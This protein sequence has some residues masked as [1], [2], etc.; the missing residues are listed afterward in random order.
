MKAELKHK[1]IYVFSVI[2]FA[3]A[4]EIAARMANMP[5]VLPSL[6]SVLRKLFELSGTKQFWKSLAFSFMRVISAFGI[7]TILG[8]FLGFASGLC[9]SIQSFLKFPFSI[10]KATPVVALI[11]IALFW[12]SSQK[13]PVIC[14]VL[15]TLPVIYDA[16][17]GALQNA[18]KNLLD[19]SRIFHLSFSTRLKHV[20]FPL[21]KPY[22]LTACKTV[23]AQS[24]KVVAA[25]EILSVPRWALG[26]MLQEK[27]ILLE[28]ASV[29]ALVLA[30]TVFCILSEKILFSFVD[31][32]GA[33]LFRLYRKRVGFFAATAS[34][35]EPT[36]W[37]K[38]TA[39][40]PG[41]FLSVENLSFSYK[42]ENNVSCGKEIFNNF[43]LTFKENKTYAITG[44]SGSGKTTLLK[45]LSGTIKETEYSGK[46]TRPETSFIFQEPCLVPNTSVFENAVLP[47]L[48]KMP[49]KEAYKE[50]IY[51]LEKVGLK[52][53]VFNK[54][55]SLSG[56][57]KQ[58]LQA[59]RAFAFKAPVL[60]MDEGTASL[61]ENSRKDLW[62][63]I[64]N[65][66]SENPRTFIFV[67][68]N[69]EEAS[70]QAEES[71]SL[72]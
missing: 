33:T 59:A 45:I 1:G 47:L 7:T 51:Y 57:E 2:F 20:Y 48:D 24:W 28:P 25:G 38:S 4:W 67:T 14:A 34:A 62:N 44:P 69:P 16:V 6:L 3:L 43:S 8:L 61:D 72:L 10:I 21:T 17:C 26:T 15:M 30:L 63:T 71:I 18:N 22:I 54:A 41:A 42:T 49:V 65:L 5:L 36:V 31:F 52:E 23:F 12:F 13:L 66:L 55:E 53:H 9:K 19:M 46:V 29:F 50:A 35:S 37:T 64:S 39:T 58:K 11:M 70:S 60:L 56:G 68:H 32:M 27:R 40:A